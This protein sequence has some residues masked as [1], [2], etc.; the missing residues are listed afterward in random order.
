MLAGYEKDPSGVLGLG[1][2][3]AIDFMQQYDL[4]YPDLYKRVQKFQETNDPTRIE[5]IF[6]KAFPLC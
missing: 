2:G 5:E 1:G 3:D 6:F 4:A